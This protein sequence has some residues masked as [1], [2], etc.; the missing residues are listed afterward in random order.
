MTDLQV[1][2]VFVKY[3]VKTVK[4]PVKEFII[5]KVASCWPLVGIF[6]ISQKN[7][8]REREAVSKN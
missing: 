8:Y 4:I 6:Q 7:I 2:L 3:T 5:G 1:F